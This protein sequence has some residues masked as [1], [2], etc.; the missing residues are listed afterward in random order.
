MATSP[1]PSCGP[2]GGGAIKVAVSPVHFL[3]V[4]K[5]G[6]NQRDYIPRTC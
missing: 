5:V 1:L 3:G 2:L 6:E 4:P